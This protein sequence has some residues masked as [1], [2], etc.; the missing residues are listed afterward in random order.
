MTA[1]EKVYP[2]QLSLTRPWQTARLFM[3][4]SWWF[5]GSREKFEQAD[6]SKMVTTMIM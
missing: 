4:T 5:Y 6:K 2:E 3:N 1:D